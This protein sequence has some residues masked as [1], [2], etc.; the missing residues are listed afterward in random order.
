MFWVWQGAAGVLFVLVDNDTGGT[1]EHV[2]FIGV[3]G[4]IGD[5]LAATKVDTVTYSGCLLC[6][7]PWRNSPLKKVLGHPGHYIKKKKK[8]ISLY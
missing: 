1:G 4:W 5:A 6:Q 8:L 3:D 2:S 7:W